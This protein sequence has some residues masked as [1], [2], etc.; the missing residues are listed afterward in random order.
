MKKFLAIL[1]VAMLAAC[2]AT[3]TTAKNEEKSTAKSDPACKFKAVKDGEMGK[4]YYGPSHRL[5]KYVTNLDHRYCTEAEAKKAGYSVA[6][7]RFPNSTAEYIECLDGENGS[8]SCH[9]YV[10]GI[11]QS[12]K[13]YEKICGS[14][15][16]SK[17]ELA[18]TVRSYARKEESRMDADRY[19]S[20]ASAMVSKY[21]CGSSAVAKKSTKKKK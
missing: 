1:S 8:G 17:S 3:T 18:D 13:I 10:S 4:I 14:D 19:S 15:S 2:A 7:Q 6:P 12:L 16:V 20:I 5:Y 11:Y 9:N 21:S